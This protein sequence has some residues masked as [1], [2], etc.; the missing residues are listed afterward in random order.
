[1]V[2]LHVIVTIDQTL[3]GIGNLVLTAP[4]RFQLGDDLMNDWVEQVN[5]HEGEIRRRLLGLFHQTHD[6]AAGI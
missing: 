1:V 3:D 4:A 5:P 2:R 6:P